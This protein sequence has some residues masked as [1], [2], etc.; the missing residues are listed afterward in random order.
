MSQE[1]YQRLARHLDGLPGGF[2][3]TES[4]VE[5]R[6]LRRLFTEDEAILALHL[7][8]IPEEAHVIA[9]RARITGEDASRRLQ[10]MARKGL[11]FSAEPEG[12]DPL[13]MAAQFVVGI[14]EYHVNDLDKD[15]IRDMNEYLPSLVK[16][17]EKV[18]QLRTIP[19]GRSIA[20][21]LEVLP[22]ERAEEL[23]SRQRRFLVAPCICRREHKMVGEG[24]DRPEETCLV[25]GWGVDFYRRNGIGRVIEREEVLEILKRADKAGLVLQPSNAQKIVN[26]CC[27][28]GCCCQVL[29]NLKRLPKPASLVSSPFVVAARPETCEGCGV[30]VERCQ[31]GALRIEDDRVALDQDRCIGCGLCVSTCPTQSLTLVRKPASEQHEVP[32]TVVDMNLQLGRKRGKLGPVSLARMQLKSKLDRL[33]ASR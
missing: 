22:Y 26:I 21:N 10:G 8:L 15:L 14:W 32:R 28:C 29:K 12:K 33:L 30:C 3:S 24:C 17:W 11:I 18:P 4:G 5:I 20:V 7:D 16:S 23:I 2:P 19:V 13:Y 9:R 6:I 25:F 31:M 27:C 1:V